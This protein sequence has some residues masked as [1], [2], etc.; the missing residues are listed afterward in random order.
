[1]TGLNMRV[2]D[3]GQKYEVRCTDSDGKPMVMGW[4]GTMKGTGGF[5]DSVKLHP[6][7]HSPKITDRETG[8]VTDG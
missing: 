5:V 2:G 3:E 4:A 6:V 8:E 1:M 7:L